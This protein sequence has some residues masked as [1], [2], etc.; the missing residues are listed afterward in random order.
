MQIFGAIGQQRISQANVVICG[1]GGIGS[2]L[3]ESVLR[4]GIRQVTLIDDDTLELSNLHRWQSGRPEDVGRAKVDVLHTNLARA[5]PEAT[6]TPVKKSVFS[7]VSIAA[8]IKADVILG[9][10]DNAV[11]RA[12][13]SRLAMQFVI[14]YIDGA[15]Q[16]VRSTST[17]AA[18]QYRVI[19]CVPGI[20]AC[21]DCSAT[22]VFDKGEVA[23]GFI[24]K[25]SLEWMRA[26]GYLDDAPKEGGV[27]V[28]GLNL[29]AVGAMTLELQ[30]Y[31]LGNRKPAHFRSNYPEFEPGF[32][33]HYEGTD[34]PLAEMA[35]TVNM[36]FDNPMAKPEPD[37]PYCQ[38]RRYGKMNA[39]SLML[40]SVAKAKIDLPDAAT[41]V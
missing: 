3:S 25:A 26:K 36:G 21:L 23:R 31:L 16:I 2:I 29:L 40:P 28:Y 8:L 30:N 22:G 32:S 6:I 18:A 38:G 35:A 4:L 7:S 5:F 39:I 9:G 27:A 20:T 14:P 17:D 15:A 12:F 19:F 33:V 1:T 37:C 24:D 10:V 13:I 11:A 41:Y 34:T